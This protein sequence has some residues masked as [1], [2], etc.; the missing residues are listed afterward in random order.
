MSPEVAA[1]AAKLE[2]AFSGG[3]PAAL[4]DVGAVLALVEGVFPDAVAKVKAGHRSDAAVA[5]ARASISTATR[6]ACQRLT[7]AAL[8]AGA[9]PLRWAPGG[10]AAPVLPA[11]LD[12][13]YDLSQGVG[14]R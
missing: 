3:S 6:A 13:V 8:D 5:A 7:R 10:A 14:R 1:L 2:A 9:A 12:R 11:F 4:V